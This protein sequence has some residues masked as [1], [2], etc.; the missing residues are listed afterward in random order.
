MARLLERGGP[1]TACG[2]DLLQ[3]EVLDP[4][5]V[6]CL[7]GSPLEAPSANGGRDFVSLVE[8]ELENYMQATLLPDADAFSMCS[9]VELRVPFVDREVFATAA[10]LNS[11][12]LRS[13]GKRL[14]AEGLG[15][16]FLLELTKKPKRGFTVPMANWLRTGPLQPLLDDVRD[17]CAPVWHHL[18]R[19]AAEPLL[20]G[21]VGERW[22]VQWSLVALNAW[23]RSM[24]RE[25]PVRLA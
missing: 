13:Q 2:L 8:A 7:T 14:L 24:Q 23:L 10:R 18:D 11:G 6:A 15:D 3:R 21:S 9:S 22:S 4:T 19:A 12:H 16:P 1:R 25:P 5:T 17:H 20:R